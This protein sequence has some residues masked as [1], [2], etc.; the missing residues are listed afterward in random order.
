MKFTAEM[1]I[2]GAGFF[3]GSEGF[4]SSGTIFIEEEMTPETSGGRCW[5][6][7]TV[8]K[9]VLN[10]ELIERI[11]HS[12]FPMLAAVTFE[13]VIGRKNEKLTITEI[14]PIRRAADPKSDMK[15]AA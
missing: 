12:G 3:P 9:P 6:S 2:K 15:K 7:R 13:E 14:V 5:G 11:A 10:P 4:S 8:A 1:I